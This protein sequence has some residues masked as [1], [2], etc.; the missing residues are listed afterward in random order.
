MSLPQRPMD[1]AFLTKAQHTSA[2]YSTKPKQVEAI[3]EKHKRDI[4]VGPSQRSQLRQTEDPQL[5][6][7]LKTLYLIG[8]VHLV[9]AFFLIL[10]GSGT[11]WELPK[12]FSDVMTLNRVPATAQDN[13]AAAVAMAISLPLLLAFDCSFCERYCPDA[14]AR[15]FFVHAIGNLVVAIVCIPDFFNTAAN[16]GS[17]LSVAYCK[18]LPAPGC[19]DWP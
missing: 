7:A 4:L 19:S 14:G 12:L 3:K 13:E 16:P 18:T 11:I 2:T 6:P 5:R 10:F 17:S 1:E 9:V 8:V 15:W